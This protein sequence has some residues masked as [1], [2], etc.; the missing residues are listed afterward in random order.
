[1]AALLGIRLSNLVNRM[2]MRRV[3]MHRL[4]KAYN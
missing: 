2:G 3:S 4:E 1:M